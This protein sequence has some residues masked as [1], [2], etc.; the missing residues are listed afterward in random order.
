MLFC[1]FSDPLHVF[2]EAFKALA[3]RGVL[4]MQDVIFDFRSPNDLLKGSVLEE[5]AKKLKEAFGSKGIDLTCVSGYRNY[6]EA[7]GF[8]NI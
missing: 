1:S 6:L 4:K 7:V 5:W 3:A 2:K 8:E